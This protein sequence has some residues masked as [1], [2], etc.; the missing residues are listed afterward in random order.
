MWAAAAFNQRAANPEDRM[1]TALLLAAIAAPLCAQESAPATDPVRIAAAQN[2]FAVE[3]FRALD[4]AGPAN[5]CVSPASV[6]AAL[7]LAHVGARNDTAAELEQ[8]LHF[9]TDPNWDDARTHTAF[10]DLVAQASLEREQAVVRV[11]NAL[12]G[13]VGYGFLEDTLAE[14]ERRYGAG[15]RLVDFARD[16]EGAAAAIN[17][18]V[19]QATADRITDLVQPDN[20]S[21]STR[22]VLTNAVYFKNF[23]TLPFS[24]SATRPVPFY[25]EGDAAADVP[26][27][28]ATHALRYAEDEDVQIVEL[29]FMHGNWSMV[30]VL[31][32]ERTGLLAVTSKLST[33]RIDALLVKGRRRR[34]T[35]AL[36]RF[37]F[38]SR[39]SLVEPLKTLGLTTGFSPSADFS[40]F[41]GAPGALFINDVLHQAF[42]AVDENGAEAAGATAVVMRATTAIQEEPSVRFQADHPFLFLIRETKTGQTLFLGRVGN[43]TDPI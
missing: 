14:L 34:V 33:D 20:L 37:T 9:P 5:A 28:H 29:P 42:I 11:V 1:K 3:L 7:L 12:W 15:M 39:F 41:A 16:T 30:I 35:L 27:M 36:P 23:W 24:E 6:Y 25:L 40:G 8:V 4:E 17:A 21:T 18:W 19:A 10:A 38:T 26:T 13:Q 31:P 22:L 32:R 43:P 2:V